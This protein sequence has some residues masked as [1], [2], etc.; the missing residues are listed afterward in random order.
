MFTVPDPLDAMSEQP[1]PI[2]QSYL[3]AFHLKMQVIQ[4]NLHL[5]QLPRSGHRLQATASEREPDEHADFGRQTV[6]PTYCTRQ[7][8]PN[9]L[10]NTSITLYSKRSKPTDVVLHIH[11]M[12]DGSEDH[13]T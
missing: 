12:L 8:R 9:F 1:P 3:Y 2:L 7:F 5:L 13:L 10:S 6:H 11:L 4:P